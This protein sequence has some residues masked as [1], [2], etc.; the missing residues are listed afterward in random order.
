M[1]GTLEIVMNRMAHVSGPRIFLARHDEMLLV[2]GVA[3]GRTPAIGLLEMVPE[4]LPI[5]SRLPT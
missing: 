4:I 2:E 1:H 5:S 3:A